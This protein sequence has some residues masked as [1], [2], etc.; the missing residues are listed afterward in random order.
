MTDSAPPVGI[1]L[2]TTFSVIACLDRSGRP[3]TLPNAEGDLTT[4]SAIFFDDSSIIVGKEALKA[5]TLEPDRVARFVKREMGSSVFSKP[6]NGEFLPP[7][8]IQSLILEKLGR[9]AAAK[10]GPVAEAVI[11]VPAYYNE[12]RRKA[13]QD[14]GRLAGLTVLDIIN[15]PTAAAIAYGIEGGFLTDAGQSRRLENIVIYDLGG[16]TFD[17]SVMR[18][19]GKNYTVV[20][21]D[22]DVKLGGV[23]W[24]Q[25]KSSST[26]LKSTP[27]SMAPTL[28]TIR[29]A[30]RDCCARRRTPSGPF[31]PGNR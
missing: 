11:T 6:I 24:D 2:G 17:A 7:E 1:D 13:T 29:R 18:I 21:T 12:P 16:G 31:R 15:E 27:Q 19:D 20:A 26:S 3:A 14:A 5:A 8:V 23:D 25:I 10:I 28:G 4:P 9:D 22:G 30:F